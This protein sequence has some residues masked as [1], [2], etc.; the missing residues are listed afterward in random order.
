M[1]KYVFNVVCSIIMLCMAVNYSPVIAQESVQV[2]PSAGLLEL[3]EDTPPINQ[4]TNYHPDSMIPESQPAVFYDPFN[5]GEQS[6]EERIFIP[7]SPEDLARTA[8]QVRTFDCSTVSEIPLLECQA[9]VAL[10]GS[11]NGTGWA[12]HTN[13]L[14]NNQPS[15]WDGVT[16]TSGNVT[17]LDL[18]NNNLAGSIPSEL[19]LLSSLTSLNLGYNYNMSGMIP[20]WLGTMTNLQYLNLFYAGLSGTIPTEIGNMTN[21]NYLY[22]SWNSLS[23]SIPSSIG[24][25]T[26]LYNLDLSWSSL[27]GAIPSE[28]GNLSNLEQLALQ[29]NQL[30]G[31]L[32]DQMASLTKIREVSIENNQLSGTLPSWLGSITSLKQIFL[33][34][35][36]FEGAIPPEIGNITGLLRLSLHN[37]Q[38]SGPVPASLTN[39]VNLCLPDGNWPCWDQ[40]GL[41]LGY[42]YLTTPATPQ[43]L[44]DFLAIKDPDWATT[45]IGPFTS[46]SSVT[47]I[48]VAECEALVALYNST[49]GSG[50]T[51][52]TNWLENN[53]PGMWYGV[54]VTSGYVTELD[55]QNNNLTGSIPSQL[56]NLGNLTHLFLSSNQLTGTI[57]S[58][59]GNLTNLQYLYL[60]S[61]QLSGTIPPVLGGLSN[62]QR[63]SLG[64]NQL[65]GTIPPQLG[66]LSN[67]QYLYLGWNQLTGTIPPEL[68]SLTN[69]SIL[70]LNNNRLSGM[71]P[72]S[73]L[74]LTNLCAGS[75]DYPCWGGFGL[76]V[77]HNQLE[78][79]G[80]STELIALLD[81]QD[82]GWATTQTQPFETNMGSISGTV[83]RSDGTTPIPGAT[84]WALTPTGYNYNF[85]RSGSDGSYTIPSLTAGDY[86][87][88]ADASGYAYEYFEEA[89]DLASATPVTVL[90]QE[91]TSGI[92]FTLGEAGSISGTVTRL[93]GGDPI[94]GAWVYVLD[95][96]FNYVTGMISQSTGSYQFPDLDRQGYYVGVD[97]SGYGSL[98]YNAAYDYT[99]ADL[100]TV[101]PP[102][103]TGSINFQLSQEATVSGHVYHSDGVTPIAGITVY[104]QP[105]NG[106]AI[107]S[108]T[109]MVDGSFLIGGLSIGNY[110][111]WAAQDGYVTEYYD[112]STISGGATV[113][114]VTQP[115]NTG[116]IDFS[117]EARKTGPWVDAIDMSVVDSSQAISSI[118][119]GSI[120]M[121]ASGLSIDSVSSAI[122]DPSIELAG[123]NGMYYELTL[124][125]ATFTDTSKLN[126]FAVPKIRE[127]LN[128]LVDRDYLNQSI[129]HGLS[130]EKFFP[131]IANF[132]D[133]T[134]FS[135]KVAELETYY[136]YNP[137]LAESTITTE[138]LALGATKINGQ[139][140]Y[141]GLP[142]TIT[143]L[144]R[145]DSDLKRIPMGDYIAD[146]L[147]SI[148][149]ATYRRYLR[150]SEASPLW[151]MGNPSDGL[152]HIYT[153]AWSA[154]MIDNDEGDNYQFFYSPDSA[155]GF[156]LL[157]QAYTITQEFRDIC[158]NLAYHQYD[159]YEEY[160]QGYERAMELALEDSSRIWLIDG[161]NYEPRRAT[162]TAAYDLAAGGYTPLWAHTLSF[163]E[164]EGGTMKVALPD[165][166]VDPWN[167]IAG[168]NWAFDNNPKL[169]IGESGTITHP[170][171][172]LP[173]PHRIESAEV[174]A[175]S[176]LL[177]RNNSDWLTLSFAD[178]IQVP[179]DAWVD[180]NATSQQF[181]TRS[182]A[183]P[184][185]R[186][187]KIKSVV[188]Y[189]ADLFDTVTWHDGSPLELADFVM[190]MII[191]F[192]WGKP[193]SPI[194]DQ[195][196]APNLEY[197]MTT[198]RGVKIV[199]TDPLVIESYY[200]SWS[201]D[202]EFNVATWWPE[203]Y[204]GPT[205]WHT[206]ALASLAEAN[207]LL[208]FSADKA[209]LVGVPW[210][211]YLSGSSISILSDILSGIL[212]SNYIP[213]SP[214]MSAYI[215]PQEAFTRWHNL[216]NWVSTYG[217]F[218][219]GTG[220]FFIESLDWG[221]KTMHLQ[222]FADYPD[223]SGRYDEFT[224]GS[225]HY[226]ATDYSE[227]APGSTFTII[228]SNYPPN[229]LAT[230]YLNYIEVGTLMTDSEG[231][232]EFT[233]N[234]PDGA[235]PGL[236][237][238]T[239]SVNPTYSIY[240]TIDAEEPVR[241]HEDLQEHIEAPVVDPLK[242]TFLPLIIK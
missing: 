135:E 98:Y 211:N 147:E 180:W 214:T 170:S 5:Q 173:Q 124:N 28:L 187:A 118:K 72:E 144:I 164:S 215:T 184:A 166:F 189:P 23:G 14:E 25:L 62:L 13:W 27:S 238:V 49:N 59:L 205:P 38:L 234:I 7:P 117:L 199:S 200:E 78:T 87:L 153:G 84:I 73:F 150:S 70:R 228:G 8:E 188:T 222:R 208:A 176:D 22:L 236:Y 106:G 156:S 123:S 33:G 37:N 160:Y 119:D 89:I 3:E 85:A 139:W 4:V 101:V 61:N 40:Y 142:I 103:E 113:I 36:L 220:P 129:F 152:W 44:A 57:P 76:T 232:F 81:I 32:P 212:P 179:A 140:T 42:N 82:P 94:A 107:H 115:G 91:T 201:M 68:G 133:Y 196:Y 172:G 31:S 223:E 66:S 197:F 52:K 114:P 111:A 6:T 204:Y 102:S 17:E 178:E 16:V 90:S 108:D 80:Y 112:Q 169:A 163:L 69:L 60:D 77:I 186:T 213:Y 92:D 34:N 64:S 165:L 145:N 227:G 185:G 161:R 30:T 95:E 225:V 230:V 29:N 239:V 88:K 157:W 218:W 241:D 74:N 175:Q 143:V 242:Q 45:Q 183:F 198:F 151:V 105:L 120:D 55:L 1:K 149:F 206:T 12:N 10:Y 182:E 79:V 240:I 58:E 71:I 155:Y 203:A 219:L 83:Y 146:Q 137:T 193:E 54:T 233:I 86:V 209:Y 192:D 141:G 207:L 229:S 2:T 231:G 162:T 130:T 134:R 104:A 148:G 11:T 136:A 75:S 177:M 99:Q 35:N 67:L 181:I 217:H 131:M 132:P 174:I 47:A 190:N 39:L 46:C 65:T 194:F 43:A 221:G 15:T 56:G 159:T 235:E 100:V 158:N 121:Y 125:P 63:L 96:N 19:A 202:A 191:T 20:T 195:A 122:N 109:S 128:W 21:L 216:N 171:T 127:A 26:N 50:W 167:P 110:F 237:L 51:N 226:L 168:S 48:P 116:N 24:N 224:E 154:T 9:L 93:V 18:Y 53:Q 126:P 41:N 138:M 97:V 210:T